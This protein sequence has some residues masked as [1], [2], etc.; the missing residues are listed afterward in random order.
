PRNVQDGTWKPDPAQVGQFAKAAAR[1]YD[2]RFPD[3][4]QPGATLPRVRYWQ[5]WNEPNL[6]QYLT[7]QWIPTHG[8]NFAAA[9]PNVYRP[10][11]NAFYSAVKSVD[12]SNFVLTAGMAPYGNPHGLSLP[13][14]GNRVPP[15]K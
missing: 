11:L 5:A 12:G 8:G 2:G 13:G 1:R 9:S 10:L 7:P 14:I 6:D 3:P 15:V 4:S